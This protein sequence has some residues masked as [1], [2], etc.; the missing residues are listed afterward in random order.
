M[1]RAPDPPRGW[2]PKLSQATYLY[3][4]CSVTFGGL[5]AW[6]TTGVASAPHAC[7]ADSGGKNRSARVR[8]HADS[9]HAG[10]GAAGRGTSAR[11]ARLHP[12]TS[13]RAGRRRGG[14]HSMTKTRR[15]GRPLKIAPSATPAG[16]I[17]LQLVERR[18]HRSMS[19]RGPPTR[20]LSN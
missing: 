12:R 2:P 14:A 15:S 10:A 20:C 16:P 6:R 13:G 7:A 4:L 9:P 1:K 11:V 3:A 17:S 8:R 18:A 19:R 5:P